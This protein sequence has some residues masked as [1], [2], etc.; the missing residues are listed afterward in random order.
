MKTT[1]QTIDEAKHDERKRIND[2]IYKLLHKNCYCAG[3]IM[4]SKLKR[5]INKE[6][7]DDG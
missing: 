1:K 2:L 6:Q 7:E 4:L 3:C 5:K